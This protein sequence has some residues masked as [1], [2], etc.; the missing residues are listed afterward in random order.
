MIVHKL[1]RRLKNGDI[2]S[3]FINKKLRLQPDVWYPAGAHLTKGFA[4]RPGWHTTLLPHA[5]H[6]KEDGRVW[7]RVEI[8][9]YVEIVRPVQQGG[10]W[11]LAN[12]MRVLPD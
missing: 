8:K 2:A 10:I 4:F 9:D 11:Y 5:P 7:K 12:M 3:L 6:L 1:F